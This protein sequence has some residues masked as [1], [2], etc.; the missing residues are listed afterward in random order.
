MKA[1][2]LWSLTVQSDS[3][4]VGERLVARSIL[5][6]VVME[7]RLGLTMLDDGR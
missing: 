3:T 6:V 5:E 1:R 7:L 4:N 2:S